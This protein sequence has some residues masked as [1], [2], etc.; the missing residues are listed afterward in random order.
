[1]KKQETIPGREAQS[2]EYWKKEF[3]LL[4]K[5]SSNIKKIK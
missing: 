2:Y 3:R 1:V 4:I 5:L